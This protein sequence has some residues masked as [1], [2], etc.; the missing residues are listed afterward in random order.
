MGLIG[1]LKSLFGI[2]N[3][4][5]RPRRSDVGVTVEREPQET[6][7]ETTES[8]PASENTAAE[9]VVDEDADVDEPDPSTEEAVKTSEPDTETETETTDPSVTLDDIKGI[10]PAYVQRLEDAGIGS[11]ADLANADADELAER[12][13]LSAKRVGR[14][15]ERA[16]DH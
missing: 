3:D 14:W 9:P 1:K 2:E 6:R 4:R 15:I 10:G 13:E 8:E 12:T 5:S 16:K 11:V 7:E